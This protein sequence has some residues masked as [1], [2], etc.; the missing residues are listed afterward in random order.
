MARLDVLHGNVVRLRRRHPSLFT[1]PR[2]EAREPP[3]RRR[4]A[5]EGDSSPRSACTIVLSYLAV[6]RP[7]SEVWPPVSGVICS[8]SLPPASSIT[9]SGLI[10]SRKSG[11]NRVS[12][13]LDRVAW[14]AAS[15]GLPLVR[16]FVPTAQAPPTSAR[17]LFT[18]TSSSPGIPFQIKSHVPLQRPWWRGWRS[19]S[20]RSSATRRQYTSLR[21][22]DTKT[23][24]WRGGS[25]G[26][27]GNPGDGCPGKE[28]PLLQ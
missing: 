5:S 19:G 26:C 14:I 23:T 13:H 18:M 1:G 2:G 4:L 8:S 12:L 11:R 15:A 28:A 16:V 9:G 7:L 17:Q 10:Y 21:V 6:S 3:K 24:D 20:L 27:L 25:P 22:H